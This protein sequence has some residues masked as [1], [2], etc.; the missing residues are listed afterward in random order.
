VPPLAILPL[1]SQLP[2]DLQAKIFEK[3]PEG[4]RK[5]VV[6]TNVAETSLTID[7]IRYVIDIGYSKLK[8]FN[9]RMGMDALNI[10]PISQAN[11]NQRSGRAGR[12]MA[13]QC[14]RLFT[15]LQY[16]SEMLPNAIPEIQRT[17]LGN[18]V[19]LLKSLGVKNLLEFQFLD[20]PPQDNI[21]N[22]MYQLWVL[23]ALDNTGA[24]TAMGRKMVEFPLDPPLSKML[25]IAES[26]G[27][28]SEV[29]TVVSM[30]SIP[31][32]FFRPKDREAESDAAREKFFVPESDHLTLLHVYNQWQANNHSAEWCA[33]HF[34]HVKALRKVRE[35]RQQM[36]DIMTTLKIPIT[37]CGNNWDPVR[38]A[39]CA[40]Y[41]HNAC[42]LKGER[43]LLQHHAH[44]R[45]MCCVLCA[46]P[47]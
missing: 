14:F 36:C 44:P 19:L 5:C 35:V 24:L 31:T 17:N 4:V 29:L 27:C 11:A 21:L 43:F 22:S 20:P 46:F 47:C 23:G 28:T 2:A 8:V 13:G 1:Y 30:L 34:L 18:V 10:T 12:T 38:K 42:R 45:V 15:E 26:L 33:E 32:I 40:S 16:T 39:I 25:L 7:G 3:P 6:S 41:F 9:P 37:S